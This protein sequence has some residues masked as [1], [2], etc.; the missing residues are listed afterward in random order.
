MKNIKALSFT[1]EEFRKICDKVTEEKA[2]IED[3]SGGWFWV[4]TED[5]DEEEVKSLLE[6]EFGKE[7]SGFR[8]DKIYV[9]ITGNT[10]IVSYK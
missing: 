4:T 6:K 2:W 5:I 3:E 10:V 8:I 1:L 9:D 7:I